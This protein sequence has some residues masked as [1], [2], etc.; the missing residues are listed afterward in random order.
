MN[1]SASDMGVAIAGGSNV[2]AKHG[3][4]SVTVAMGDAAQAQG[5]ASI[6]MKAGPRKGQ[7]ILKEVPGARGLI[8]EKSGKFTRL[9]L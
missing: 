5:L 1:I 7:E 9:G 3:C 2:D 8:I 6:V 4:K